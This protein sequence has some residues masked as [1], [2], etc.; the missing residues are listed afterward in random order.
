MFNYGLIKCGR[1]GKHFDSAKQ[2]SNDMGMCPLCQEYRKK[3]REKAHK[4]LKERMSGETMPC[5]HCNEKGNI[6][7]QPV[8]SV[9]VVAE[10]L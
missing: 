7:V 4:K 3:S 2:N 8:Q 1:C 10:Y 9:G 5:L 6:E